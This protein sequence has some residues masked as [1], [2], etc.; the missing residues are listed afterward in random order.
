VEAVEV[1]AA[2]QHLAPVVLL[3]L[4]LPLA[5]VLQLATVK[6]AGCQP[7]TRLQAAR[8]PI[9]ACASFHLLAHSDGTQLSYILCLTW[10]GYLHTHRHLNLCRRIE[11]CLARLSGPYILRPDFPR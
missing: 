3:L 6:F 4:L 11:F 10:I 8:G 9:L 1:E 5:T 2:L 7:M